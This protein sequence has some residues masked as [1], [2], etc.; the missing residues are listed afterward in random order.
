MSATATEIEKKPHISASQLNSFFD[1]P[2]DFERRYLEGIRDPANGAMVLGK[3]FHAGL[4]V[5]YLQKI[6]SRIDLPAEKIVQAFTQAFDSA[7]QEEEVVLKEWEDKVKLRKMGIAMTLEYM[8]VQAPKIQPKMVE[9]KFRVSLGDE[10]PFDLLGFWDVVDE[11][12]II[13]DHK[14]FRK[15]PRRNDLKN[16]RQ[17]TLYSL[18][19]RIK[20]GRPEGGLRLDVIVKNAKPKV[21]PMETSRTNAECIDLLRDIK[22]VAEARLSGS[23]TPNQWRKPMT[24]KVNLPKD[25]KPPKDKKAPTQKASNGP[26]VEKDSGK[27]KANGGPKPPVKLDFSKKE[28]GKTDSPFRPSGKVDKRLKLF[29]WGDSGSGKTVLA[30]NFPKPVV[31]DMEG[32]SEPYEDKYKFDVLHASTSDEVMKAVDWLRL[33]EHEFRTFVFDP[34]TVYWEALQKKWSDIFLSRRKGTKGHRFEFYDMQPRD[35]N[36]V[37]G[38]MKELIRK[39]ISLDMNVVVTARE[40]TKYKEG[41]MM[42]AAGETFDGEKGLPYLFDTIIQLYVEDSDK[43]LAICK[44]DRWELLPSGPF[45]ANFKLFEGL[46]GKESLTRKAKP[47]ARIPVGVKARIEELIEKMGM[48]PA[49]VIERLEA[50]DGAKT[51]DELTP[52]NADIVLKKL[53]SAV[54]DL[55]AGK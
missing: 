42:K 16:N 45:E 36:T 53:E 52:K 34:V 44:K 38:E 21:V 23:L 17:L 18:A 22:L 54:A 5:N 37:K 7:F 30:L 55:A 31:I 40:K 14:G 43:H 41:E 1:Y 19:W 49:Q 9:Q 33:N 15:L 10:F 47:A 8:R 26:A 35:W 2:R 51:I 13:I 12:D 46:F 29:I 24:T 28:S 50:Y 27:P 25:K 11:D 48:K 39:I 4:E 32:S 6:E 20:Y 3:T